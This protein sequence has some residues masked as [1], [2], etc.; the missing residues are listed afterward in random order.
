MVAIGCRPH[1][2]VTCIREAIAPVPGQ[3]M[4]TERAMAM[5][6]GNGDGDPCT[7]DDSDPLDEVPPI[8]PSP[9]EPLPGP[10]PDAVTD[11]WT[12]TYDPSR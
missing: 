4:A 6:T 8:G 9:I 1:G 11:H 3:A 10:A 2:G 5:E 12:K 7:P